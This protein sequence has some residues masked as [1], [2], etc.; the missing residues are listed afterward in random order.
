MKEIFLHN[1]LLQISWDSNH[2][3]FIYNS[4]KPLGPNVVVLGVYI[5]FHQVGRR[6][7]IHVKLFIFYPLHGKANEA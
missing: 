3:I 2:F 1:I 7:L 6:C 5:L 4:I